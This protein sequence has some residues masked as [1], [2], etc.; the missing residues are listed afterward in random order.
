[1]AAVL[2][3]LQNLGLQGVARLVI[4]YILCHREY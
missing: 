1:M 4:Q 2:Y 3:R